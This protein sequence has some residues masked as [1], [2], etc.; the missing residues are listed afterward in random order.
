MT[1]DQE[2]DT[3]PIPNA[4]RLTTGDGGLKSNETV[5]HNRNLTGLVQR[6]GDGTV[7]VSSVHTL[8]VKE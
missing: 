4:T 2:S 3:F 8:E 6:Q 7:H 5:S 1:L